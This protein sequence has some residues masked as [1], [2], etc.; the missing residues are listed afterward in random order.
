MKD[1]EIRFFR[2]CWKACHCYPG[3]KLS[4]RNLINAISEFIPH[5][6]CWYLLA[7]WAEIGFYNYGVSLDLGWFEPD[8]MPE[9][10][11]NLIIGGTEK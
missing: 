8:K 1:D 4:F 2:T 9:R 6:R 7:K 10:Y 11:K 5:K 3:L